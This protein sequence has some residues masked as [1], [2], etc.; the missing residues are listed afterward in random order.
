[1][2]GKEKKISSGTIREAKAEQ[3]IL[4]WHKKSNKAT[5]DGPLS[6][7]L[8][9]YLFTSVSTVSRGHPSQV[10]LA[11]TLTASPPLFAGIGNVIPDFPDTA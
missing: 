6:S 8:F 7:E 9:E 11:V 10:S 5:K 3:N 1:V 4:Y 2:Y